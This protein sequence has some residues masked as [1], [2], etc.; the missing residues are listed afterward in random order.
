MTNSEN[1]KKKQK[2]KNKQTNKKK[3][4]NKQ[5]EKHIKSNNTT[6]VYS[7]ITN[8]TYSVKFDIKA[9]SGKLTS[10]VASFGSKPSL[11]IVLV[12][13]VSANRYTMSDRMF[14]TAILGP[15]NT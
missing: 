9:A 7:I 3:K 13:A 10:N 1:Q 6:N 2:K 4:T 12:T 11:M 14:N 15:C 8:K 5:K